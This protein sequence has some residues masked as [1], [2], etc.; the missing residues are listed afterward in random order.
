MSESWKGTGKKWTLKEAKALSPFA[1]YK[2][3]LPEKAELAQFYYRQFNLRVNSFVKAQTI[4]YAFTKLVTDF[5]K[6]THPERMTRDMLKMT[7][8]EPVVKGKGKRTLS[9]TFANMDNPSV[10]L[11]R[12]VMRMQSFFNSKS[13]TVKGWEAI[14]LEQDK[15]L[16]G[17]DVTEVKKY[18][19]IKDE[20]GKRKRQYYTIVVEN[21]KYRMTDDERT[22]LWA[23]IDMAKEA[24]WLNRFGY[25]S[26]QA[27]RQIASLWMNGEISHD[28][29][30]KAYAKVQEILNEKKELRT[31]YHDETEGNSPFVHNGEGE[32]IDGQSDWSDQLLSEHD[33]LL[34]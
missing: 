23:I 19:Y 4:P 21:P 34:Q 31:R 18:R 1:V 14:G 33:S 5:E 29:I 17:V 28:D 10:A 22:K 9:D 16:F 8:N 15:A 11:N 25:S 2:M 12:Y 32:N 7:I 13:S 27:H 26:E 20:N 24:G 3:S 30:D 6:P